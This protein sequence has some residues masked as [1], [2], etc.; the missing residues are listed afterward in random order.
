MDSLH[1]AF[2]ESIEAD[3]FI[4]TDK[5]LLSITKKVAIKTRIMSPIDFIMEKEV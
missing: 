3:Y 4:T 2:A 5:F 1:I